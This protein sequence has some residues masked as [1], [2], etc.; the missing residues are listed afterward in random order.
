MIHFNITSKRMTLHFLLIFFV[1][2]IFENRGESWCLHSE[3]ENGHDDQQE[4]DEHSSN[5]NVGSK[6][7]GIPHLLRIE[8]GG[9]SDAPR[10]FIP[11]R[12]D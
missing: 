8:I 1:K 2:H 4:E 9:S 5:S 11:R 7:A 3:P 10:Y 12:V 6:R